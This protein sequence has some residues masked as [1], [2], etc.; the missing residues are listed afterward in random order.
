MKNENGL[1]DIHRL[2]V[3]PKYF[4]KGIAQRLLDFIERDLKDWTM[5]VVSTGSKNEPAIKFYEKNGFLKTKETMIED[6]L[7]ITSLTKEL[8]KEQLMLL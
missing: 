8:H 6:R 5:I 7:M 4:R 3:H 1:V 2:A